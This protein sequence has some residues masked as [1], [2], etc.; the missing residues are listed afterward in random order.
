[1][2]SIIFTA[3]GR[4]RIRKWLPHLSSKTTTTSLSSEMA[5]T[6]AN[7]AAQFCPNRSGGYGKPTKSNYRPSITMKTI[8]ITLLVLSALAL[9]AQNLAGDMALS[10]VLI[11]GE[12]WEMV[13][14]GYQFTDAPCADSDGNFYFSDVAKGTNIFKV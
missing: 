12:G 6:T 9:R 8:S 14:G 7:M 3:I 2:T 1:M 13:A 5:G 11:D 4:S 10:L